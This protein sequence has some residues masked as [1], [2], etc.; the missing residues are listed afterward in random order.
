[1]VEQSNPKTLAKGPYLPVTIEALRPNCPFTFD[2]YVKVNEKF[3]LYIKAG[4]DLEKDRLENLKMIQNLKNKNVERLF[5][6]Q[7]GQ[8]AFEHFFDDSITEAVESEALQA[9]EKFALIQDIAQTAVEVAFT[10]PTSQK[11][12]QLTEKAAQGLRKVVQGNPG[13]LKN[14]Y[15]RKG[16][17]TNMI[18]NHCKSVAALALKLAFSMGKRGPELDD[19]GAAAL[20]HDI[21]LTKLPIAELKILFERSPEKFSPDDKRLYHPHVDDTIAFISDK[22]FVSPA[23][24]NLVKKHEEKTGGNG[25]PEKVKKLEL[26]EEILALVDCFD[27]KISVRKL[28]PVKAFKEL[29]NNEIGNYDLKTIKKLKEVLQGEGILK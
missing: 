4:D 6:T 28:D 2:L 18:E 21:G 9:D 10:D 27:K 14:L 13:A 24:I 1:M 17:D 11:A 12:Y 7:A 15:Q 8:E 3:I 20:I 29:Q 5:I 19:L 25:Y 26:L 16:K 23:I 22:K